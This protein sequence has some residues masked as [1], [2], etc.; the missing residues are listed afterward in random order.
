ML[1]APGTYHHSVLVGNMAE[2]AADAVGADPV[3]ARVGA[4]YHDIG[5]IKRP[6][7]FIEN[8]VGEENPHDKIAPSLSTLIVTSHVKDGYELCLEYKLPQA[9]IDIVQQHHGTTLVSYFYRQATE[10]EHGECIIE[11]DF[12]YEGPRPQTKEAAL[13]MLADTCEA[14]VRSISKPNINRVEATVRKLIRERLQE[15]QLDECNLTLKDLNVIGDIF[16]RILSSM[17]HTRIEY[18]DAKDFERRNKSA[19]TNRQL[20]AR[21]GDSKDSENC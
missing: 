8:L 11:S 18:P 21:K 12:H 6:Y 15:G 14:A 19:G 17:F 20:T 1:D 13:V 16:I 2:S 7:F 10:N 4:Y 3:T 9:I 5:K